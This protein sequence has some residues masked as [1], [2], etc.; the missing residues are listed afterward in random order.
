MKVFSRMVP[1]GVELQFPATNEDA[2]FSVVVVGLST[3]S[4]RLEEEIRRVFKAWDHQGL[5][6][7]QRRDLE[8]FISMLCPDLADSGKEALMDSLD[9]SRSGYLSYEEFIHKVL[10]PR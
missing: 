5:G 2:V 6:G 9:P 4:D 3:T 1:E 8:V 7:I 10:V